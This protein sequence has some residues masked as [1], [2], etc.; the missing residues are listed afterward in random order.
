[1]R[2]VGVAV[3]FCLA[4][5]VWTATTVVADTRG[6]NTDTFVLDCGGATFTIVTPHVG[7]AGQIVGTTGVVV[8]QQ[9]VI[10]DASGE[11]VLFEQGSFTAL[12][13]SVLT[14]CTTPI[15]GGTF[16]FVV[17]ITPPNDRNP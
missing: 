2:K 3:A 17:M 9:V 12:D 4:V 6:P 1:M 5:A 11:T 15:P 7:R 10:T 8:F 13:P 16:T 14:T